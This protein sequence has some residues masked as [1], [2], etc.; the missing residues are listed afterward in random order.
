MSTRT[1]LVDAAEELFAADGF[2]AASLRAV[3][4]AADADPGSV[5]YH[6]GGR[7]A[8]ASAVL[9]RVLAPLNRHR[10]ELLEEA[11]ARAVGPIPVE[12][13]VEA[14]V[15]PDFEAAYALNHK[16]QGRARLMGAIYINP[17]AFVTAEVE[18]HF[19]PVA[20]QFM[21]HMAAALPQVDPQVTAWR[22]R[23][24]IFGLVGALLL[25][26]DEPFSVALDVMIAR[27]VT[28]GAAGLAAPSAAAPNPRSSTKGS[29]AP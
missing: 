17:A 18:R 12:Q 1:A 7:E 15:R 4:R 20:Q 26:P 5:H 28:V 25:D 2:E 19:R 6:F 29:G 14:I 24:S 11:E 13:L 21:P 16:G 8:L 9:E 23:W 22:V 10:V 3:M 27:V